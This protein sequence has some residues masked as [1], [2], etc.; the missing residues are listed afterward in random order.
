[1]YRTGIKY[2]ILMNDGICYTALVLEE[3]SVQLRFTDRSG[4]EIAINKKFIH[5][6]KLLVDHVCRE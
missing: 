4:E 5:K 1:M 2:K 6:S 3:D